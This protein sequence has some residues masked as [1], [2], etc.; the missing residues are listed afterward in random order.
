MMLQHMIEFIY[1]TTLHCQCIQ[2]KFLKD[3]CYTHSNKDISLLISVFFLVTM[4]TF[5]F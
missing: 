3:L 1:K 4:K 2:I 5:M